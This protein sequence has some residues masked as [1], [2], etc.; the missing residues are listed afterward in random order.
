VDVQ[1]TLDPEPGDRVDLP[2]HRY[3]LALAVGLVAVVAGVVAVLFF[4]RSDP[5]VPDP[6]T[7]AVDA[8]SDYCEIDA[9]LLT[10]SSYQEGDQNYDIYWVQSTDSDQPG[11]AEVDYFGDADVFDVATCPRLV[12][13]ISDEKARSYTDPPG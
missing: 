12:E 11:F 13:I 10:V 8:V 2:R 5:A 4:T 3:G 7:L 9:S 6:E 1:E